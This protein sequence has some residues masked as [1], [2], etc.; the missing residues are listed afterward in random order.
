MNFFTRLNKNL[1]SAIQK[2]E[3]FTRMKFANFMNPHFPINF[4]RADFRGIYQNS[5]N[6]WYLI[7]AK[8]T[9]I[10]VRNICEDGQT[11]RSGSDHSVLSVSFHKNS[12]FI[13]KRFC[14]ANSFH[15][16]G[17]ESILREDPRIVNKDLQKYLR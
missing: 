16:T 14:N 8:I 12:I 6:P 15:L 3:I 7:P 9:W 17:R 13:S 2:F 11:E 4:G 5:Q 1:I 10:K